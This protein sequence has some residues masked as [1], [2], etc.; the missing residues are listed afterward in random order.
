MKIISTKIDDV[1]IIEPVIFEDN[2]G[3]F[4]ESFN[5]RVFSAHFE[6]Y[7]KG[8]NFV[9]D[10]H[11]LSKKNVIRGLHYQVGSAQQCKLVRVISGVIYDVAVDLRSSSQTFGSW[12]GVRLDSI[13]NRQLWIPY[14]F[15]HGFMSLSD[16]T[17]VNYKTT[18]YYNK[19]SERSI[20]WND[21]D[22]N[23]D[24]PASDPIISP[25][26]QNAC[27]FNEAEFFS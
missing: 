17:V 26:D 2:R 25:K 22:I 5:H 14:G 23:I 8:I 18:N 19:S 10:N 3:I 7:G 1:K 24:W 4:Y 16:S 21:N 11:S 20:L 6:N 9:Q 12:V 13:N 15:A 27:K